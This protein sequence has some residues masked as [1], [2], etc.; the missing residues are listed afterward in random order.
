M[1]LEVASPQQPPAAAGTRGI[2]WIARM[3]YATSIRLREL[4]FAKRLCD[5]VPVYLLDRHEVVGGQDNSLR[6]KLGLRWRLRRGGWRVLERGP[7]TRF[8]MPVTAA[9]GPWFNRIAA[10]INERRIERALRNFDCDR[11]FHSCQFFFLP[12]QRRAYRCHFD[13]VDN[14]FEEWPDTI[15]DRSRKAFLRDVMRRADTLS[16]MSLTMCDKVEAFTGRR[17]LYLPNSADIEG[18]AAWPRAGAKALRARLGL[19]G[20]RVAGFIGNHSMHFDGME[21]LLDAWL[22]AHRKDPGLALLIVGPGSDKL[23]RPRGLGPE[24]GVHVVGPVPANEVWNYFLACDLGLHT[25]TPNPVTNDATPLNVVEFG[26]CGIPMLATALTELSRIALPHVRL[27]PYDAAAWTRAL[28][29]ETSFTPPDSRRLT[30]AMRTFSWRE[31]SKKLA[32]AME[33]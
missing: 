31:N 9:T 25:Y 20:R 19:E 32:Q 14:F 15:T 7:I 33:L 21:M 23:T 4:E 30:E 2:L 1:T 22:P 12:P 27:L 18:I 24:Q 29:E 26:A 17:P 6:A 16:T 13:L 8:A 10:D 28:L 5:R 3:L 11:V